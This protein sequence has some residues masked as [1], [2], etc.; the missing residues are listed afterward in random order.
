MKFPDVSFLP[1]IAHKKGIA[2]SFWKMKFVYWER[3]IA[4]GSKRQ[5]PE[6]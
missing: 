2:V 6:G 4:E 1:S 3:N 5:D